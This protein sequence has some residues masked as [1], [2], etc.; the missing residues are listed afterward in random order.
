MTTSKETLNFPSSGIAFENADLAEDDYND[1]LTYGARA[2]LKIDLDDNWTVTPS[3]V[4]QKAEQ[5]RQL[6]AGTRARRSRY[7]QF[8]PEFAKDKWIQ[9]P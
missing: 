4:G 1:V 7:M 9:A 2:A 3:Q 5:P 8:N 6:R